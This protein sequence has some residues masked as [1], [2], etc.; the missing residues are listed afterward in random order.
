MPARSSVRRRAASVVGA[1]ER[2]HGPADSRLPAARRDL[3]AAALEEH[4]RAVVNVFPPLS[5]EQRDKIAALLR[6]AP[7]DH[8]TGDSA[9]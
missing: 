6:G 4:V 2:H 1:I 3:R 7:T 9:R 5:A 8:G